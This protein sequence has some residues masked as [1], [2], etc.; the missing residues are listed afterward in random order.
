L[1][2]REGAA[3]AEVNQTIKCTQPTVCRTLNRFETLG[4]EVLN[5]H[6]MPQA[7]VKSSSQTTARLDE[8]DFDPP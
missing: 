8:K 3:A 5:D 4:E 2:L 1:L 7:P 6:P